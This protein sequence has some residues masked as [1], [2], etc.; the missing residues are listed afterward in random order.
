MW[1]AER[2][3]GRYRC[4]TGRTAE[5]RYNQRLVNLNEG[6]EGTA[7]KGCRIRN[8]GRGRVKRAGTER[9]RLYYKGKAVLFRVGRYVC[10]ER[11]GCLQVPSFRCR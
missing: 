11:C 2:H 8:P 1:Y 9:R 3:V 5:V 10:V 7:G 4:V 6:K